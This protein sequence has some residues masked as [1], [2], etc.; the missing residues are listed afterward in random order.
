MRYSPPNRKS[1]ES[2][3]R[4]AEELKIDSTPL[5]F[6]KYKGRTPNSVSDIDPQYIVWAAKNIDWFLGKACSKPLARQCGYLD[7]TPQSSGASEDNE[8]DEVLEGDPTC[9]CKG[10]QQNPKCPVHSRSTGRM[11]EHLDDYDDDIPF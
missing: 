5:R 6:G 4:T 1:S 3:T 2:I 9:L 7:L 8:D 10:F 11:Q